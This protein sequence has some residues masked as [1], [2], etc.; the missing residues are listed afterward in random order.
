[1]FDQR[2]MRSMK[3]KNRLRPRQPGAPSPL[4]RDQQQRQSQHLQDRHHDAGDEHDDRDRPGV[5]CDQRHDTAPDC[6]AFAAAEMIDDEHRQRHGGYVEKQ[7]RDHQGPGAVEA[8]G[9]APP[10]PGL[11]APAML[12]ATAAHRAAIAAGAP[13]PR[14]V[15]P[16]AR[17]VRDGA[18]GAARVECRFHRQHHADGGNEGIAAGADAD[19]RGVGNARIGDQA[20]DQKD[21]GHRPRPQSLRELQRGGHAGRVKAESHAGEHIG[22]ADQPQQRRA[23]RD[24]E[25]PDAERPKSLRAQRHGSRRQEQ[26]IGGAFEPHRQQG[27]EQRDGKQRQRG[28]RRYQRQFRSGRARLVNGRIAPHAVRALTHPVRNAMEL[29]AAGTGRQR[30]GRRFITDAGTS[31][32]GRWSVH[33]GTRQLKGA[34]G[35]F[36][37]RETVASH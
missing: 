21:V 34:H 18:P 11:A 5:V 6:M 32:D 17:P 36:P 4:H 37:V 29:T 27:L 12:G 9:L 3:R 33:G 16:G 30:R 15:D 26:G 8:V 7:C 13:V 31:D 10:Q 35:R 2:P 1:M 28:I 20:A 23:D 22:Q 25:H 14:R 19:V 24:G